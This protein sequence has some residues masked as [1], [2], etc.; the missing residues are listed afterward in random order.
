MTSSL[1]RRDFLASAP[2]GALALPW[3]ESQGYG[4]AYCTNMGE[5][6][7]AACY[8]HADLDPAA[9]AT[10]RFREPGPRG[11][12]PRFSTGESDVF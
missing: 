11:A 8:K 4:M 3:I 6:R 10:V 12:R 9:P 5:A 2:A 7:I 1:S